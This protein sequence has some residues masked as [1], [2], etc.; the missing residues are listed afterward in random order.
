MT[1]KN[2]PLCGEPPENSA[3]DLRFAFLR[4]LIHKI[5]VNIYV[6]EEKYL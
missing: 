5:Y 6:D 3:V 4:I 2:V 1:T